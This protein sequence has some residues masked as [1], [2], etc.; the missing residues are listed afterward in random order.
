MRLAPVQVVLAGHGDT[1][2]FE[3]LATD[4]E[5]NARLRAGFKEKS[6]VFFDDMAAAAALAEWLA[7]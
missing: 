3:R 5:L 6:A 7:R 4:S 1:T 2:G